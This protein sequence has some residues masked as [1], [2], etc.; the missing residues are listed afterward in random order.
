MRWN[1]C[2]WP[3][4]IIAVR[5]QL[6]CLFSNVFRKTHK[7][8]WLFL[9]TVIQPFSLSTY[10]HFDCKVVRRTNEWWWP[11]G[12][13]N[14]RFSTFSRTLLGFWRRTGHGENR[15]RNCESPFRFFSIKNVNRT[16]FDSRSTMFPFWSAFEDVFWLTWLTFLCAILFGA[17]S[18]CAS[19][20]GS[21]CKIV[22]FANFVR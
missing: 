2:T 13:K 19:S 1:P 9:T 11:Q 4:Y 14:A 7:V 21:S 16:D 6:S 22:I 18:V 20:R 10:K 17:A 8:S 15:C 12:K 3:K 5:R